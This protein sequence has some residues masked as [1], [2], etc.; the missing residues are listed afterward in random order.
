[1]P[2]DND[3]IFEAIASLEEITGIPIAFETVRKGYDVVLQI[4]NETFYCIAKKN[5]KNAN[6][7]IIMSALKDINHL[8]NNIVIADYLTKTT[9]DEL[10]QNGI[11]YL[12]ASGN[13]FIK[14]RDFFVYV[15]GRKAKINKNTNQT[16]AF[17]EAGLK[18]ILLLIS[19]PETVQFSYRELAEKTGIALGSVSNIFNE[20]EESHYL[21]K[22]RNKRVLKKLD[23]IIE[24]WVIAYNELLKPRSFR[25]RMR[26][27]G[28]ESLVSLLSNRD[29]KLY[30]GGEPGGQLL[31]E[32]LKPKDYVIYTN[33]ELSKV[34][35]ELK[36]VPD[37][38]GNIELYSK[39]WTDSLHL[40]NE[41]A[42]PPLVVYA[43]LIGTGNNRN[44]ET[45]KI[46]LENGLQHIK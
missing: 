27:I 8:Q 21:L 25:K 3:F 33:E 32:H 41:Y 34:A 37:E 15:E 43:D 30:F 38:S 44:I 9:T 4:Y 19:N 28:N 13:A 31:T 10:K 20:L 45:A 35:K 6:Y 14:T 40:K 16:R 26:A 17:Q 22:T 23:E 12:D 5:A 42:A 2:R 18:L 46:I 1:M 29:I 7:G 11:N 39:F 36:L 24:R